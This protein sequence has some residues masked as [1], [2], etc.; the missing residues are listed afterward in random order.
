[1]VRL[2]IGTDMYTSE[3]SCVC[4]RERVR[5]ADVTCLLTSDVCVVYGKRDKYKRLLLQSGQHNFSLRF[6]PNR[7]PTATDNGNNRKRNIFS[8]SRWC[9]WKVVF[10][11]TSYTYTGNCNRI[12]TFVYGGNGGLIAICYFVCADCWVAHLLAVSRWKSPGWFLFSF[13]LFWWKRDD[14]RRTCARNSPK[15]YE[16]MKEK[17]HI[18]YRITNGWCLLFDW[19]FD[20]NWL[21]NDGL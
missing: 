20:C 9:A 16:R 18:V 6:A 8:R 10:M 14:R 17:Q 19:T 4:K 5:A 13:F 21:T 3:Y 12:R 1:M 15:K 7:K 2:H 11:R